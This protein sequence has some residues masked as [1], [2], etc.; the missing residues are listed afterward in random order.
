MCHFVV[1]LGGYDSSLQRAG[2]LWD[3]G[4]MYD[5]VETAKFG[6]REAWEKRKKTERAH[7]LE[8][9]EDDPLAVTPESIGADKVFA[10]HSAISL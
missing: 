5:I 3:A 4:Q 2:S 1:R 9:F 7:Q 10:D 6:A 8:V